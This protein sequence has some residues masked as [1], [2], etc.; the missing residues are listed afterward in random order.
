MASLFSQY[1]TLG[2]LLLENKGPEGSKRKTFKIETQKV[3]E[4][5][6]KIKVPSFYE[7]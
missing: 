1:A 4:T 7:I 6:M 5:G 2:L 3:G